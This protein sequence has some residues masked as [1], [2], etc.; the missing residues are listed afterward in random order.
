[1]QEGTMA[2]VFYCLCVVHVHTDF[3]AAENTV[4]MAVRE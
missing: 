1:M 4:W 3:I 2:S